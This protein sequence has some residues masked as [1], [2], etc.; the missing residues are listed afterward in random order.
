VWNQRHIYSFIVEFPFFL[1][2]YLFSFILFVYIL[3]V[4]AYDILDEIKYCRVP[5]RYIIRVVGTSFTLPS[6]RL[7]LFRRSVNRRRVSALA[8]T[9]QLFTYRLNNHSRSRELIKF[10]YDVADL[11]L[12]TVTKS[13]PRTMFDRLS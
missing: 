5:L 6:D 11:W 1:F 3:L 7:S 9:L 10:V 13:F 4:H 12:E 2:F 8:R